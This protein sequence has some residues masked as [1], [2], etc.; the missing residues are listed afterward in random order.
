MPVTGLQLKYAGPFEEVEFRFDPQVNVLVG[1]NNCGKTTVLLALAEILLPTVPFPRKLL[2]REEGFFY[3][4]AFLF[5]DGKKSGEM[6]RAPLPA[7]AKK[8]LVSRTHKAEVPPEMRLTPASWKYLGYRAFI[9]ALRLSTDFRSPGPRPPGEKSSKRSEDASEYYIRRARAREYE[10]QKWGPDEPASWVRD[11]AIIQQFVELDYRAYR[12]HKPAV[13][14]V[15]A[16]AVQ[17]ASD[18]TEGFPVQFAGV[19]EDK[20]GYYPQFETP[21]GRVPLNVLSQGTQSLIQWCAQFVIGYAEHYNFPQDFSDK[22]AILIVDEIDAHLHPSWQRR[23]LPTLTRHYPA[24]QVFCSTHSPLSLAGLKAGQI[25]LMTRDVNGKATVSRNTSDVQGW[26]ADEIYSEFLGVEPTDLATS[27]TLDRLRAL[28]DKP[29]RLTPQEQTELESLREQV[30]TG[31][32]SPA[33]TKGAQALAKEIVQASRGGSAARQRGPS[34]KPRNSSNPSS[35]K[36][37]GKRRRSDD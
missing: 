25:H 11:A 35:K 30:Q 22:P 10:L 26:S 24:L 16:R 18:I 6:G 1:P 34:G 8:A 5:T 21:D 15:I 36:A 29:G 32:A 4:A 12:E 3:K 33:V 23:I 13:R 14:E 37:G 9:P 20:D 19:G 27:T 2:R 17:L 7:D 28:R 31:L